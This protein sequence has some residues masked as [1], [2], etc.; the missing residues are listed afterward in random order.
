MRHS[1]ADHWK[2]AATWIW[3]C[4]ALFLCAQ[5]LT[6]K[7]DAPDKPPLTKAEATELQIWTAQLG[8]QGRAAKTRIEA[9]AG[10]LTRDYPQAV[11]VLQKFLSDT[12]NRP[13]QV[14]VAEAIARQGGGR[15]EFIEPL[16]A[17]L[18]GD[19]P[20]VRGSAALALA[21][22]NNHGVTKSLIKIALNEQADREVRVATIEAMQGL[23]DK[24]AVDTLVKLLSDSDSAVQ[25]AALKTLA[26]LTNISAFGNDV[27]RWKRWWT[28]NKNKPR[29]VWLADLANSLAVSRAALE[30]KNAKLRGRLVEAMNELYAATPRDKRDELLLGLLKDSLVTVRLAGMSLVERQIAAGET[31]SDELRKQIR[32]E[33]TDPHAGVRQAAAL[34][35]AT[36]GDQ[37][38]LK[39][40]MDRLK[41]EEVADVRQSL[42]KAV[43]QLR[44]V[45]AL[46]M[47]LT[48]LGSTDTALAGTAAQ[49]LSRIAEAKGLTGKLHREA[50]KALIDRYKL[51]EAARNH[52]ETRRA[53]LAAMGTLGD[54]ASVPLL[55]EAVKDEATTVRLTAV[56][57]LS[58][59]G[60]PG[61]A[62]A[63]APYLKDQDRGVRQAS[64]V[65]LGRLGGGDYLRQILKLTD[66]KVE[67]E[68]AVR[69]QAWAVTMDLL[70]KSKP[71]TMAE[72]IIELAKRPD[73]VSR[74]I[75]AMEMYVKSLKEA[76]S[77]KL[78]EARR[79]L[80]RALVAAKRPA[81]GAT[82]LKLALDAYQTAK[83][84][85]TAETWLEWVDALLQASDVSGI[86]AIGDQR[87]EILYAK[88][89]ERLRK[90]LNVLVTDENW[91]ATILVAEQA[92]RRLE[93]RLTDDQSG[94]ISAMLTDARDKLRQS[95]SKRVA[96]LVTQLQSTDDSVQK[97]AEADLVSMGGRVVD[98]LLDELAKVVQ[99]GE[100]NSELEKRLLAV[101][102]KVAP[103]L[104]G[105]D[106]G[107]SK[108]QRTKTIE[109]WRKTL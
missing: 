81:E 29:S 44:A 96:A 30:D 83:D 39:T 105:Y 75:E 60:E 51:I 22:Y 108:E 106:L 57:G 3:V 80:G 16:M 33:L 20:G 59:L 8:D 109:N 7:Q 93:K 73:A 9:A 13:A 17:M 97:A 67:S 72:I 1:Q 6:A 63:I 89:M 32:I 74:R 25:A 70:A 58:R 98:P 77:E 66:P 87:D 68:F 52:I 79:Q 56:E 38:S 45:E 40:L 47:V 36:L 94:S 85:K 26:N 43:G 102:R 35:V 88:A 103:E 107:G 24:T 21:T 71:E 37:G 65:A 46:P 34:V 50:S 53:L 64:I 12:T 55:E 62:K 78:P 4:A 42:L 18:T 41:V 82:Q 54:K 99:N 91:A 101:L 23:L 48:D 2:G 100:G 95:D 31:V 104:T 5:S 84:E 92:L 28:R 27:D 86:K 11:E 76:R 90:R 14:A 10:L 15:K 61:S 19:E 49:A 69:Q